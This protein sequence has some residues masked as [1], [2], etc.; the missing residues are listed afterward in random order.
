MSRGREREIGRE[1]RLR[2]RCKEAGCRL[3]PSRAK[4]KSGPRVTGSLVNVAEGADL[5]HRA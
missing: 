4:E 3:F 1:L 5:K 2:C